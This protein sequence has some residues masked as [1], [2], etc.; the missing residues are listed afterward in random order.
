MNL[1]QSTQIDPC[2]GKLETWYS[3]MLASEQ[4]IYVASY[5]HI[6]NKKQKRNNSY[7]SK[8]VTR[9][10]IEFKFNLNRVLFKPVGTQ[11][12][13]WLHINKNGEHA[14]VIGNRCIYYFSKYIHN[15]CYYM[16][17]ERAI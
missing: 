17:L 2:W 14:M 10:W 13:Y 11:T 3:H 4:C 8:T 9:R 12:Q 16:F 15:E 1:T 5:E 6:D 7:I